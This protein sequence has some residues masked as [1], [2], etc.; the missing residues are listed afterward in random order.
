MIDFCIGRFSHL[1]FILAVQY[2][3]LIMSK[4]RDDVYGANPAFHLRLPGMDPADDCT[5]DR[6]PA[7]GACIRAL[8]K[9]PVVRGI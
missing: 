1:E 6:R 9:V 8:Q 5:I 3:P 7:D 4:M 2:G